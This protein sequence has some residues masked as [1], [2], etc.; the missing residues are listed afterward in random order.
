[1]VTH[2]SHSATTQLNSTRRRVELRHRSVNSVLR[3]NST[4]S[5]VELLGYKRGFRQQPSFCIQSHYAT[6]AYWNF[7]WIAASAIR[8][9][10]TMT[11]A[12][13]RFRMHSD[14]IASSI[15]SIERSTCS[16]NYYRIFT[17]G[18]KGGDKVAAAVVQKHNCKSVR[19]PNNISIFRA[20]LYALVLAI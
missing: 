6:G 1:M 7:N 20:E 16:S 14:M 2:P 3:R 11:S 5:W 18:S 17:D 15:E 19:L 8:S 4:L 9:K 12:G 13:I 10:N